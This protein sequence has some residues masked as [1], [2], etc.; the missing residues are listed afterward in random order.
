VSELFADTRAQLKALV[1]RQL[2]LIQTDSSSSISRAR[3]PRESSTLDG[4]ASVSVAT[5][6]AEQVASERSGKRRRM[7]TGIAFLTLLGGVAFL[8]FGRRGTS[9]EL[10]TVQSSAAPS[11]P[12]AGAPS[13]AAP[14]RVSVAFQATPSTATLSLDGQVLPSNP[15]TKLLLVD[16]KAHV[17]R[18]EAP[19]YAKATTEFSPTRDTTIELSLAPLEH[20]AT[21]SG[22]PSRHTQHGIRPTT[23][24]APQP[25]PSPAANGPAKPNCDSPIFLDKDGIR[26]VRPE[27]R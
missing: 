1:E 15:T 19:G 8:G 11:A 17:L 9:S 4:A 3:G 10:P 12:S 21:A 14:G 24:V 6:L 13:T 18:A 26:R 7:A 16:G 2:T 5:K 23:V 27:C 20:T 25:A 22:T